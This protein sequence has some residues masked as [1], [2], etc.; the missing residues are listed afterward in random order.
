MSEWKDPPAL[1]IIFKITCTLVL[2]SIRGVK[3]D[4]ACKTKNSLTRTSGLLEAYSRFFW[5]LKE[6]GTAIPHLGDRIQIM[7]NNL[8]IHCSIFPKQDAFYKIILLMCFHTT[9]G[10]KELAHKKSYKHSAK[11]F[12]L[13]D[14][15]ASAISLL[16]RPF[17]VC[18]RTLRLHM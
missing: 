1:V 12:C 8:N 14:S 13:F 2:L 18:K 5:W 7:R 9:A 6:E 15:K 3:D 10:N 4:A 11:N 17:T 16:Q